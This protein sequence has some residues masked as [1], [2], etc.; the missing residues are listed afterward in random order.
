VFGS[1]LGSNDF[2]S[3]ANEWVVTLVTRFAIGAVRKNALDNASK[4]SNVTAIVGWG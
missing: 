1:G 3:A 4:L 2:L